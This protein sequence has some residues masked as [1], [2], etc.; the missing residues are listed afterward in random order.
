MVAIFNSHCARSQSTHWSTHWTGCKSITKPHRDKYVLSQSHLGTTLELPITYGRE[1]ECSEKTHTCSKRLCKFQV[2]GQDSIRQPFLWEDSSTSCA[3]MQPLHIITFEWKAL[4]NYL[5]FTIG[6]ETLEIMWIIKWHL[7][8]VNTF[9]TLIQIN[10]SGCIKGT[11]NSSP[12]CDKQ[13]MAHGTATVIYFS[14]GDSFSAKQAL[15]F[16]VSS[17]SL[18][19]M[20]EKKQHLGCGWPVFITSGN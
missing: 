7:R 9:L 6:V 4:S 17:P 15:V 12:F 5:K 18:S 14:T 16:S 8:R 3:T 13:K 19:C 10:L 2:P 1:L 11:Y 20:F